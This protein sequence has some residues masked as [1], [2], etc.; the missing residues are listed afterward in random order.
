MN[1]HC[2]VSSSNEIVLIITLRRHKTFQEATFSFHFRTIYIPEPKINLKHRKVKQYN[3]CSGLIRYQFMARRVT[4]CHRI[5]LR[6]THRTD[7]NVLM[8]WFQ[9]FG[10]PTENVPCIHGIRYML[11]HL[12]RCV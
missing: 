11:N 7:I 4:L 2:L 9:F 6:I 5:H 12:M 1:C 8:C 10:T 3:C